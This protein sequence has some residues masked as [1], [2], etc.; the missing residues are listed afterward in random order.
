MSTLERLN[1]YYNDE[2]K[3][4]EKYFTTHSVN[5]KRKI[6]IVNS[7]ISRC[8]GAAIFSEHFDDITYEE[9]DKAY[10]E[11]REKLENLLDR[12]F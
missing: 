12:L 9:I 10:R 5:T 11:T 8:L 2:V 4:V 6:E 3:D 7:S 1:D